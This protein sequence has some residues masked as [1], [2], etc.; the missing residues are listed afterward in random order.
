MAATAAEQVQM[1]TGAIA[2]T[3]H[4]AEQVERLP[5]YY[6]CQ[7]QDQTHFVY[8]HKT[9]DLWMAGPFTVLGLHKGGRRR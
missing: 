3:V 9:T 1:P 4:S 6:Q 2:Y 8:P 7:L 5:F